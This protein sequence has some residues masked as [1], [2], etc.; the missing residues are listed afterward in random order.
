MPSRKQ[1]GA[2]GWMLGTALL[3]GCGPEEDKLQLEFIQPE[4]LTATNRE[5]AVAVR[6]L[7]G[8]PDRVALYVDDTWLANLDA[9]S[10]VVDTRAWSEGEHLLTARATLGTEV[11][12]SKGR[13][14]V[15]DRTPPQVVSVS[16]APGATNI[17]VDAPLS[18]VFS[19][20]LAPSSLRSVELEV[21]GGEGTETLEPLE[22]S[23]DG[24][25]LVFA[26]PSRPLAPP[27]TV[28]AL[29]VGEVRDLV[30]NTLVPARDSSWSWHVP[31]FVSLG[32][33]MEG[34]ATS[35]RPFVHWLTLRLDAQGKPMVAWMASAR[36]VQVRR[37][38]SGSQ[39]TSLP[40][41]PLLEV[42]TTSHIELDAQGRPTVTWV[43][44]GSTSSWASVYRLD[45]G[46]WKN[47]AILGPD[48]TGSF[49]RLERAVGRVTPSG[50]VKLAWQAQPRTFPGTSEVR[51][52]SQS[53]A[54]SWAYMPH[55]TSAIGWRGLVMEVDALSEATLTAW[56]E[57]VDGGTRVGVQ[58]WKQ[59]QAPVSMPL[60]TRPGSV[61]NPALVVQRSGNPVVAWSEL[62]AIQ[63]HRWTGTAWEQLGQPLPT[64]STFPER[65]ETTLPVLAL[66][67][68][69]RLLVAWSRLGMAEVWQWTESGWGRLGVISR[70][71]LQ[72]DLPG[73]LSLQVDAAGVPVLAWSRQGTNSALGVVEVF[74]L[75]R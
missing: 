7:G 26:K 28:S 8:P 11:F 71:S 31:E 17:P 10:Y 65:P 40:S 32:N 23:A 2:W 55:S 1:C 69:G 46:T 62:G 52:S 43:Q 9:S 67:G 49:P 61:F 60:P 15:V 70:P 74:R 73:P 25:T 53:S 39:W 30:G 6:L 44:E 19:E 36:S 14:V 24:K 16:P 47:L 12:T 54:T 13:K 64:S 59:A 72:T 4:E 75:N 57:S 5:L 42:G 27:R 35:A 56:C 63:V 58:R 38:E 45:G 29:L 33:A 37:W 21:R 3:V 51:V 22:L 18:I 20:P 34:L 41:G 66:D 50:V 48:A 68:S